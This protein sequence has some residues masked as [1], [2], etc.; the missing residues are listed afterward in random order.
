[1]PARTRFSVWA[2]RADQVVLVADGAD[3]PMTRDSAGWWHPDQPPTGADI[4]YGYR[5]DGGEQ[6]FPDPRSRRQ[7]DGVHALS[8]TVDLRH[9]WTDAAWTGRQ[10]PGSV[11]YELHVGTFTDAGTLDAAIDRLD[12]L[13]DLGVDL[14]EVMPVNAFNGDHG[15]GYDGVAWFAV[16]EP[17]GGPEAY[18]RFV[19]ACHAR[20]L[21]V[22]QDVVYN[23]LGPSGN[24]LPQFGPYLNSNVANPW[25]AAINLD[26]ELSDEVRRYILDNARMWLADYHVDG[27]RLDAVHALLDHRALGLLEEMAAEVDAL[28]AHVRRPLTLIAESDL[29]DPRLITPRAAGGF[30]LAGQWSDDFHHAVVANLTG[31][32]GGYYRDFGGIDALAAVFSGG[33]LHAGG[34]SSFRGRHHGRPLP[35]SAASWQLVV[36]SDNHDQIGNRHDGRRLATMISRDRLAIA[37]TL[38]LLGPGTPMIFQGE[39]WGSRRPWM[40]F[41]SHPEEELGRA[42]SEGRKSEFARMEWDLD[43]VPDP[44]DPATFTGSKVAW[45]ELEGTGAEAEDHRGLFGWYRLLLQVRRQHEAFTSPGFAD[46]VTGADWLVARR[47]DGAHRGWIAANLGSAPVEVPAPGRVVAAWGAVRADGGSVTLPGGGAAV[48]VEAP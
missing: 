20:G 15:W 46:V 47:G 12:H 21:G 28:S 37:A 30:G 13:V 36:C 26:G 9:T 42:V 34:Y 44:Q 18:A 5:L 6:V 43:A 35:P 11:I 39:E 29:N 45:H 41:T 2:P 8:Q 19:D 24:Y 27:L 1:M 32:T 38:T 7:P 3:H 10:L 14:V 17:Y 48:L 25:G 16:H 40:F 31:D 33:F 22:I 4:R 23:H